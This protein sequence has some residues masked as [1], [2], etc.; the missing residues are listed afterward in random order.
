MNEILSL[1]DLF[2]LNDEEL[3]HTK[4]R[5]CIPPGG[6]DD[7]PIEVFKRNPEEILD[8]LFYRRRKGFFSVGDN[9]ICLVR[10]KNDPDLWL[11]AAMQK[12]VKDLDVRDGRAYEGKD[13]ERYKP[14]CGRVIIRFHKG[15]YSLLKAD[16]VMDDGHIAMDE[17]EV[18]QVLS[19]VFDD[20]PFPGYDQISLPWREVERIIVRNLMDWRNALEHQK[21]VYVITDRA[22]GK[23]YVGSATSDKGMLLKR[24]SDYVRDGH[25]GDVELRK[26]VKEKGFDYVKNN[27]TYTLLENWNKRTDDQRILERESWWKNALDSR[28]HGYNDN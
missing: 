17:F 9:A 25:G 28:Q 6:S 3:K 14:L 19:D 2:H 5:F 15:R 12:V 4:I 8:W 23:L 11:F 16:K 27:F 20:N 7:N 13:F 10:L 22:T 18:V 21:G 26:V 1:N 24:W